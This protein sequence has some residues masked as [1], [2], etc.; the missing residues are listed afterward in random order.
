MLAQQLGMPPSSPPKKQS[1]RNTQQQQ[2]QQYHE[3]QQYHGFVSCPEYDYSA[4]VDTTATSSSYPMQMYGTSAQQDHFYQQPAPPTSASPMQQQR[5]FMSPATSQQFMYHSSPVIQPSST[6]MT[7]A[8]TFSAS[9]SSNGTMEV[10]TPMSEFMSPDLNQGGKAN[11]TL[12]PS[13]YSPSSLDLSHSPLQHELTTYGYSPDPTIANYIQQTGGGSGSSYRGSTDEFMQAALGSNF[14][15]GLGLQQNSPDPTLAPSL[16]STP[17]QSSSPSQPKT[18][19][20]QDNPLLQSSFSPSPSPSPV[21]VRSAS[22]VGIKRETRKGQ[23]L[24]LELGDFE[25]L[26]TLGGGCFRFC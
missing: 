19:V 17:Q 14:L 3:E 5:V 11:D 7:P 20:Y 12:M 9:S 4:L 21:K 1:S 25:M 18:P 26:E 6:F 8:M 15:T 13:I 23:D 22:A 2:Q 16:P 10:H 24:G